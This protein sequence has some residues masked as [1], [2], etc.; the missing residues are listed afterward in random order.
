[1]GPSE[2]KLDGEHT[3]MDLA[4]CIDPTAHSR[5]QGKQAKTVAMPRLRPSRSGDDGGCPS[6]HGR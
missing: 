3:Y 6:I 2:N 5:R 4:N 1:M